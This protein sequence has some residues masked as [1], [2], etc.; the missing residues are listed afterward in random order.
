MADIITIRDKQFK[1]FISHDEIDGRIDGL[2][3]KLK[4]DVGDKDPIFIVVLTG[5]FMF[6]SDLLKKLDFH[7]EIVFTRL[8]SYQ[9]LESS[10]KVNELLGIKEDL[11]DRHIIILEDIVDSG[12]TMSHFVPALV[13]YEPASV[14]IATLFFKPDALKY[15]VDVKYHVF[16]IGNEFIVGYGLDYDGLGRNLKDIYKI[17]E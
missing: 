4:D 1:T 15:P 6:A 16:D 12:A 7:C 5:A 9:G 3:K 17:V 8:S 14:A 10:G 13:K 2:A 11:K